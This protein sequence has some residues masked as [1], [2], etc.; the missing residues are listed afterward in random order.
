MILRNVLLILMII[1]MASSEY[2]SGYK[3]YVP[4][5]YCNSH[6]SGSGSDVA[7]VEEKSGD[8]KGTKEQQIVLSHVP[9]ASA[10]IDERRRGAL[11]YKK[12]FWWQGKRQ[13]KWGV[14]F[15]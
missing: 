15:L 1:G 6:S 5:Y 14:S 9:M 2:F 11:P 10:V 3:G 8:F 12:Y 7:I 13:R 4:T